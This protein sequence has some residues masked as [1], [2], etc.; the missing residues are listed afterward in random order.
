[1]GLTEWW[2]SVNAG[3]QS[4]LEWAAE[5]GLPLKALA[6]A[7][8]EKGIPSLPAFALAL[9][10]VAAGVVFLVL[11]ALA[12]PAAVI[13]VTVQDIAGTPF[14]S[15]TV[16]L[17]SAEAEPLFARRNETT[18]LDGKAVFKDAPVGALVQVFAEP[19]PEYSS[20]PVTFTTEPGERRE[21]L[22]LQRIVVEKVSLSVSV[23]GPE[24]ASVLLFDSYGVQVGEENGTDVSFEVSPNQTYSIRIVSPGFRDEE[25]TVSVGARN[26]AVSVT[27]YE[28]G[29]D[30]LGRVRVGVLD[31]VGLGNPV[32]NATVKVMD[33][34][35][36]KLLYADETSEDGTMDPVDLKL[37][38]SIV[39]SASAPDFLAMTSAPITVEQDTPVLIRLPKVTPENSKAIRVF[40]V[41]A[42]NNPVSNPIVRLYVDGGV[43]E[44]KTP[45]DG[46]TSFDAQAGK[47]VVTAWKTG[48]LPASAPGE[49]G[50]HTIVLRE[51]RTTN[52][53]SASVEVSDKDGLPVPGA[54]VGLFKQDGSPLGIPE[55]STGIDGIALFD[56][57]PLVTV[58]A[59][60]SFEG[61][62]GSS[63]A[64]EIIAAGVA[65]FSI[66]LLPGKG[67]VVFSVLDHYSGK[68]LDGASVRATGADGAAKV[69][70]T[71]KGKCVVE[72]IEG[73]AKAVVTLS[74]YEAVELA[75]FLVAP[76]TETRASAEMVSLTVAKNIR[77]VFL[78]VFDLNGNKVNSLAPSAHYTAKYLIRDPGIPFAKALAHIRV[79]PQTGLGDA[80]ITGYEAF[81]AKA[82]AGADYAVQEFFAPL[83]APG[84]GNATNVSNASYTVQPPSALKET[85]S[86]YKWV[87]FEFGKFTG[88]RELS[89]QFK[90]KPVERGK[91]ELAHRTA[92]FLVNET[93]RDPPDAAAGVSKHE[94]LAE[95]NPPTI[96]PIEF[97]GQCAA[98]LCVQAWL[99]GPSGK[100]ASLEPRVGEE[101]RVGFKAF[102]EGTAAI[103]L[104]TSGKA[105]LLK[106]GSAGGV[107]GEARTV[108]GEQSIS[109]TVP[110]KEEGVEGE[111][112]AQA[113]RLSK[114]AVLQFTAEGREG[115]RVQRTLSVKVVGPQPALLVS[116]S[117]KTVEA[118][119]E[120]KIVFTITDSMTGLPVEDAHVVLGS[121]FDVLR[122]QT[123][124]AF[125]ANEE[126]VVGKTAR[127][128]DKGRYVLSVEPRDAGFIDWRVEADGYRV[129]RGQIEVVASTVVEFEP[130]S[131]ALSV[132]SK[133]YVSSPVSVRNLLSSEARIGI[134]II[135]ASPASYTSIETDRASLALKDGE[136]G[137][138]N[139]RARVSEFVLGIADAPRILK[140]DVS[141]VVRIIARAG[142]AAQ[143]EE[144]PFT[145]KTVF[146]QQSLAELW[147][148]SRDAV[149]FELKPPKY[150]SRM[151]PLVITNNAPHPVVINFQPMVPTVFITPLSAVVPAGGSTE[152]QVTS[153]AV[154]EY[155]YEGCV[156]EDKQLVGDIFVYATFQGIRSSKKIVATIEIASSDNCAPRDGMQ[157]VAPTEIYFTIP[158]L[159]ILKRNTDGSFALQFPDGNRMLVQGGWAR[160]NEALVGTGGLVILPP[161]WLS[162]TPGLVTPAGP[163]PRTQITF[164][165]PTSWGVKTA[166]GLPSYLST[167]Q[168]VEYDNARVIFPAGTRVV[169]ASLPTAMGGI[170]FSPITPQTPL[171]PN[172]WYYPLYPRDAQYYPYTPAQA[173]TLLSQSTY[174]K[175]DV[176]KVASVAA[177][178]PVIVEFA[179]GEDTGLRKVDFKGLPFDSKFEVPNVA[180]VDSDAKIIYLSACNRTLVKKDGFT[181][182]A[183]PGAKRIS[184]PKGRAT[185]PRTVSPGKPATASVPAGTP[186]T[187]EFCPGLSGDVQYFTA[188]FQEPV[189]EFAF[190][191]GTSVE[192]T[193]YVAN[194]PGCERVNLFA[195]REEKKKEYADVFQLGTVQMR[196]PPKSS[197]GGGKTAFLP[198]EGEP[199]TGA[200]LTAAGGNYPC[201]DFKPCEDFTPAALAPD[202]PVFSSPAQILVSDKKLKKFVLSDGKMED[203]D[204]ITIFNRGASKLDAVGIYEKS[205]PFPDLLV[206]PKTGFTEYLPPIAEYA[207]LEGQLAEAG[208][209]GYKFQVTVQVPKDYRDAH[210]CVARDTPPATPI[211]GKIIIRPSDRDRLSSNAL[212]L[213]V[214][215]EIQKDEKNCPYKAAKEALESLGDLT[216]NYDANETNENNP[217]EKMRLSFKN[218]GHSRFVT[219]INN[220]PVE[221]EKVGVWPSDKFKELLDCSVH[222]TT[223][224]FND[225]SQQNPLYLAPAQA[226]VLNCTALKDTG[227]GPADT[228]IQYQEVTKEKGKEPGVEVK[229]IKVVVWKPDPTVA[230]LYQGT[231]Q[232][233]I[234]RAEK[235][236]DADDYFKLC[237]KFYCNHEQASNAF[238]SFMRTLNKYLDAAVPREKFFEGWKQFCQMGVREGDYRPLEK[239]ITIQFINSLEAAKTFSEDTVR[240]LTGK[241]FNNEVTK[242]IVLPFE[243]R[244]C[245]IYRFTAKINAWCAGEKRTWEE[246][247]KETVIQVKAEKLVDCDELTK[248]NELANAAILMAENV[249]F[250][251]GRTV[252]HWPQEALNVLKLKFGSVTI[253]LYKEEEHLED[254][255]TMDALTNALYGIVFKEEEGKPAARAPVRQATPYSDNVKCAYNA[256]GPGTFFAFDAAVIIA[257]EALLPGI[258]WADIARRLVMF[259]AWCALPGAIRQV[260]EWATDRPIQE[261]CQSMCDCLMAAWYSILTPAGPA[262]KVEVAS[263]REAIRRTGGL[264]REASRNLVKSEFWLK[265]KGWQTLAWQTGLATTATTLTLAGEIAPENTPY[266]LMQA[267]APIKWMAKNL[268]T[269]A[270]KTGVPDAFAAAEEISAQ[271]GKGAAITDAAKVATF[272]VGAGLPKGQTDAAH[273]NAFLETLKKHNKLEQMASDDAELVKRLASK[274]GVEAK[275][276]TVLAEFQKRS[277]LVAEKIAPSAGARLAQ[278]AE[279]VK[280][281]I[282]RLETV[283]AAA[284]LGTFGLLLATEC[285]LRPVEAKFDPNYL[286]HV[287]VFHYEQSKKLFWDPT[288]VRYSYASKDFSVYQEMEELCPKKKRICLNMFYDP[289]LKDKET[290]L[291]GFILIVG[292]SDKAQ[293]KEKIIS[294]FF[295]PDAPVISDADLG[296][297]PEVEKVPPVKGVL[298][299]SVASA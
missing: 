18:D 71:K 234:V 188:C 58:F 31:T 24:T 259:G 2:D 151:Q 233:D 4:F 250:I 288:I 187:V 162:V 67:K 155:L 192:R 227:G 129:K 104:S 75:E 279:A 113:I 9:A 203:S 43:V 160:Q 153:S 285:D 44:E 70:S 77:L 165:F 229:K 91:V 220:L 169:D 36:G 268:R 85:P 202:R 134:S 32:E 276:K 274:W 27:L 146:S 15:V 228:F 124:E 158:E 38:T 119:K 292:L 270:I 224:R 82:V 181:A 298:A 26:D 5:K 278:N 99:E 42:E 94:L 225:H 54:S 295:L 122:G 159:T 247:K 297:A 96:I 35:T 10:A 249:E 48:Y 121:E 57:V 286:N 139:L 150:V 120:R 230:A 11:P 98:G 272:L 39:V 90:T 125:A 28:Q 280:Q 55:Q 63:D 117:P 118:L 12:P 240:D 17:A 215:V 78:G 83:A 238:T 284:K 168:P 135:R 222:G 273:V 140:E 196:F 76:N 37:G 264:T 293:D 260:G 197:M 111:F 93:V 110:G 199:V 61:R 299:G 148:L 186:F 252:T 246:W 166:V 254:K 114:D 176:K 287:A 209:K 8:E 177:G 265:Q 21:T 183:L 275:P 198:A 294:S 126:G 101:F 152:F 267:G 29:K 171:N 6:D 87:N 138:F 133:T 213:P 217:K 256:I 167:P 174:Y 232:G 201:V 184:F 23:K 84:A 277:A 89:V 108:E 263:L 211:L 22:T 157:F 206:G 123:I 194:A 51:A 173:Y 245:G 69:C 59:K 248:G 128:A 226:I 88:T 236:A 193:N 7:L 130:K 257:V 131:L 281:K 127:G 30:T 178:L 204:V 210:G 137:Q 207:P 290:G 282:I 149:D 105:V 172:A 53:G 144:I 115:A 269:I 251:D 218:T 81:G 109:L 189:L 296:K 74:G 239:T 41:D 60:A 3:W 86:E 141:G 266:W 116:V 289:R 1:M 136:T 97:E 64:G 45:A 100:G 102:F 143:T 262:A 95:I 13:A 34:A 164:P 49:K 154:R 237:E 72:L 92:F 241:A 147:S 212:D 107:V 244:G 40:V 16:Y 253:G 112:S 191:E 231:P 175:R 106:S 200:S 195:V 258:G 62:T 216:I 214:V 47:V 235:K 56:G 73:P 185:L 163:V 14:P 52:S 283:R 79:G 33:E 291:Q 103:S 205:L 66:D 142:G 243:L 261:G 145:V 179:R 180:Y 46:I 219:V 190:S 223:T 271:L 161:A 132:D 182:L 25:R 221:V 80:G 208:K 255:K 156:M 68:P 19:P 20:E 50:S 242:I 65:N 170:G